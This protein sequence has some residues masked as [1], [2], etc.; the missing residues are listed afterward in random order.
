MTK[1][2]ALKKG[3]HCQGGHSKRGR[4]IARTLNIPFPL[5]M[6][7]LVKRAKQLHLDPAVLW[8]WR[9]NGGDT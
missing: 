6:P 2:E 3:P 8:P 4:A 7:N 5:T 9:K 1:L